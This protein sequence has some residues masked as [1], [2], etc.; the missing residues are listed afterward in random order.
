MTS[1]MLLWLGVAIAAVPLALEATLGC[2]LLLDAAPEEVP[3]PSNAYVCECACGAGGVER[4]VAI[5]ASVDDAEEA[6]A[7]GTVTLANDD[8]DLAQDSD[9]TLM[10]V[11]LRFPALGIPLEAAI[12]S[13]HVQFT[14]DESD[15]GI[16]DCTIEV[17]DAT[18]P[19]PFD[20]AA[21]NLSGRMRLAGVSESW[22]IPAWT[23]GDAG[24][25]QRTPD[26]GALVQALVDAPDWSV[27]SSIVL[28]FEATGEQRAAVSFDGD[29]AQAPTLV[30]QYEA[31]VV[32]T[33]PVCLDAPLTPADEAVDA[34]GDDLPDALET[35]CGDT[36]ENTINGMIDACG[37]FTDTGSC[38]CS[39][40]AAGT[41][42]NNDPPTADTSD[43]TEF[44]GF[45]S[46]ACEPDDPAD[47]VCVEQPLELDE[48]G[49]CTNF[50]PVEY[51]ECVRVA[52]V[53]CGGD[54]TDC[55][56]S[57]CDPFL[58]A[59][60][61]ENDT[62][63]CIAVEGNSPR[64]LAFQLL[65][66]RSLC[67]VS[68]SAEIEVGE[69]GRE[70]KKQPRVAGA[71]EILGGPC[72]DATCP[73]SFSYQL[74]MDA[75]EFDVRFASDPRFVDLVQ[76][77][78]TGVAS[79][80]LDGGFG[81]VITR[82]ATAVSRGR[83]SSDRRAYL[84]SNARPVD[85]GIDWDARTCSLAG[86]FASGVD[87]E[88]GVC[89]GDEVTPC[90]QDAPDCDAVGGPCLFDE[91]DEQA[92]FAL[93]DLT[94]TLVNQP[95]TADAG[96]SRSVECVSPAGA[97][98]LLDG[99]SSDDPDGANDIRLAA[100][101]VGS[102][103]GPELGR[104]LQVETALGVGE[105]ATYV[106]RTVDG[107]AQTDEDETTVLV[108]DTT[109]PD[110]FCNAPATITPPDPPVAFTATASDV[111]DAG[112]AAEVTGFHCYRVKGNGQ[113]LDKT[114]SCGVEIAGD[115]LALSRSGGVGN[116]IVWHAE[117]TDASGNTTQVEC[118]VEVVSQGKTK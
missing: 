91:V 10:L 86:D 50:D 32:A 82:T 3:D 81:T 51:A 84:G 77:G 4:S 97:S 13:A 12:L 96:D 19:A 26:L 103:V 58:G 53:A 59:T 45:V 27:D 42:D 7:A 89:A 63:V 93:L 111:C 108:V 39:P 55:N 105:A 48:D 62:P 104:T 61:A 9:G 37:L 90:M 60:N 46:G 11:A 20:G 43:D 113:I 102:R 40:V 76:A 14:A 110:V 6:V 79:T 54:P 116:H 8:L 67:E 101:R 16:T 28:F 57:N 30:V 35:H 72:P 100:W 78:D 75:I 118:E 107:R 73:V 23:A 65:G 114:H 33:L 95:P 115:T 69:D 29:A 87:G 83:R 68:G 47:P 80:L 24:A 70:P 88:E 38:E 106:L 98:F 41:V 71:V 49:M 99:S 5:A 44:F 85:L 15:G 52:L 17:E 2:S 109:P 92:L 21:T 22:P 117:A 25:E 34:D 56:F 18:D 74:G 36:V 64:A 31:G 1:R 66:R 112:V 94:G